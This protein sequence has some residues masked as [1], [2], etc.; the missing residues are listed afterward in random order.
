MKRRLAAI[1]AADV[2]G[3]SRLMGADEEG[4]LERLKSLRSDLVQPKITERS[5]RIVKLM[6][7]GLLAEFPSVV[8]AVHCAV[9]IQQ[10]MAVH[11]PGVPED[12]C[13]NLRIGVNLGDVIIEGSDIYGDGVNVAARLESL[14]PS[15]GICVSGKVYEEV[16]DRIEIPLENLGEVEVKNI[17]RPVAVFSWTPE[18]A[19]QTAPALATA[20]SSRIPTVAAGPIEPGSSGEEAKLLATAAREAIER[21]L[22]N[23]TGVAFKTEPAKA[24]YLIFGNVQVLGTRYRA[25][26]QLADQRSG[27]QFLSEHFDGSAED[28]FEAQDELGYRMATAI[29]YGIMDREF[30]LRPQIALDAQDTRDLLNFAGHALLG[31]NASEWHRAAKALHIALE[32][33]PDNFMTYAMK[34]T[35]HAMI[36]PFCGYRDVS[37]EDAAA[38]VEA[39][40]RAIELNEKSDF[41]HLAKCGVHMLVDR[42]LDAAMREAERSLELNPYY[43]LGLWAKGV[44]AVYSGRTDEGIESLERSIAASTRMRAN[45]RTIRDLGLGHFVAGR[46]KEALAWCHKSD[47]QAPNVTPTL[48]LMTVTATLAEDKETSA[49]AVRQ[50]LAKHPEIR[51]SD[52][53]AWP[54]SDRSMWDRFLESLHA[55]GL[56][57]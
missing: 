40:S 36:E 1:L 28:L 33:E 12:R 41:A 14:S 50:L 25:T 44:S 57:E 6:G 30:E 38:A 8:E 51:L 54:F 2:V 53:R 23:Q 17:S 47:Q 34:G 56:P 31:S 39:V 3:Y 20:Q 35:Y 49:R 13:I 24:D 10:A 46:Y 4:T 18:G 26:V 43:V 9:A 16:R 32:R 19:A 29:R 7:D 37:S 45:H 27:E 5:G 42:D 15:G 22:S 11:E 52:M 55:A 21:A 48:L